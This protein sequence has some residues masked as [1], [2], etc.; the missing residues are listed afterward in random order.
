MI[1][2]FFFRQNF[3]RFLSAL[4]RGMRF[5]TFLFESCMSGWVIF[6]FTFL[7]RLLSDSKSTHAGVFVCY[8][9]YKIMR[10]F[11]Q[12]PKLIKL[13]RNL[14]FKGKEIKSALTLAFISFPS[15]FTDGLEMVEHLSE[16]VRKVRK[17][18]KQIYD[19]VKST[20]SNLQD[21]WW[22]KDEWASERLNEICE[23]SLKT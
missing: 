2:D 10:F 4:F 7:P 20:S 14:K 18:I 9:G 3:L 12:A 13:S 15:C 21:N 16:W 19:S 11:S 23:N 5:C 17:N 8:C 6:I 22:W 1:L